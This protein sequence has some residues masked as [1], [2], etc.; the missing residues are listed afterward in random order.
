MHKKLKVKIQNLVLTFV[1][2]GARTRIKKK[3]KF[4]CFKTLGVVRSRSLSFILGESLK[5]LHAVRTG[6][7][8]YATIYRY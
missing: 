4:S 3:T 1:E 2:G 6:K 5:F 8:I 7:T